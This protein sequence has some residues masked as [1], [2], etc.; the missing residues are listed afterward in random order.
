MNL[1]N[2][3]QI[4][5]ILRD[6]KCVFWAGAGISKDSGAPLANELSNSILG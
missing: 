5:N 6:E 3:P 1:N 2:L 4:L